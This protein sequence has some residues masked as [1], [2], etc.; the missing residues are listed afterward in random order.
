VKQHKSDI[1]EIRTIVEKQNKPR[2][3]DWW[4]FAFISLV[5]AL[6]IIIVSM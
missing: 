2:Q 6:L 3:F 1:Q 5:V 4:L